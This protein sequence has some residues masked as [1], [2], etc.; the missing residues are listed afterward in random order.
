MLRIFFFYI[1]KISWNITWAWKYYMSILNEWSSVC[2]E[3]YSC[4]CSLVFCDPTTFFQLIFPNAQLFALYQALYVNV[5]FTTLQHSLL[6]TASSH[7]L[8]IGTQLKE[9]SMLV[10]M[11]WE[12]NM[13]LR[14]QAVGLVLQKLLWAWF[15]VWNG[16]TALQ[17]I[18][19]W[20]G[21]TV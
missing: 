2:S 9:S 6:Y 13:S 19:F 8:C 4:I 11:F 1:M 15:V 7:I 12:V 5:F 14:S 21:L 17:S 16:S 3:D 20:V 18:W 10:R